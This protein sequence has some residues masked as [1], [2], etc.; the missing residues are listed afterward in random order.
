MELLGPMVSVC[1]CVCVCVCVQLL[2]SCPTLCN[3]ME[4]HHLPPPPPTGPT[5]L[6]A[7]GIIGLL[8]F[9]CA[10]GCTW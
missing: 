9:N 8:N 6:P 7:L 10:S 4:S 2:Q 1:V 3:P 5:D